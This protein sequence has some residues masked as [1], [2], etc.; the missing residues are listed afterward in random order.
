M[1]TQEK[2]HL[3]NLTTGDK[4]AF[5]WLH[6]RYQTKVYQYVLKFVKAKELAEE[7]TSD[8]FVKLWQKRASIRTDVSIDGLLFKITK[9]YC[10]SY[11]RKIARNK[12]LRQEFI[13]NYIEQYTDDI[14]DQIYY[15]EGL[16][17]AGEAIRKLPPK[18]RL[19][20][21]LRYFND[22]SLQQIA[23][24]LNISKNTV[25]NH[26]NKGTHLVKAFLKTNSDLVFLV[27]VAFGTMV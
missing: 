22:L 6:K 8:V 11:F 7:I 4:E 12:K 13:D 27:I 5:I 17:L 25:Q 20:F 23:E 9:D 2:I 21:Q 10:L 16:E 26:L 24:E 14:E 15:K 18:C 3:I 1:S 19:V